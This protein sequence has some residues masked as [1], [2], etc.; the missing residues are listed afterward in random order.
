MQKYTTTNAE[1]NKEPKKI[2]KKTLFVFGGLLLFIGLATAAWSLGYLSDPTGIIISSTA[3]QFYDGFSISEVD[4]TN[5]SVISTEELIIS[6]PDGVYS[7]TAEINT[8]I[9]DYENDNCNATGDSN[10]S[11]SFENE[12]ITDG[13]VITIPSGNS[14]LVVTTQAIHHACPSEI[15]TI[16]TL[17]E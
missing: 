6:N 7:L 16:V 2:G 15:S 14:T 8:T 9:I 11:V 12:V 5:D 3:V 4:T 17:V 10:V 13:E 1:D